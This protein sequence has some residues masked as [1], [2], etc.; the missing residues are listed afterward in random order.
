LTATLLSNLS[1][2]PLLFFFLGAAAVAARSDLDIPNQIAKFLSIYLLFAIGFKGGVALAESTI[3]VGILLTLGSAMLLSALIP[4]YS[5]FMLRQA[6]ST[7]SQI[8]TMMC[9]HRSG[10]VLPNRCV[11]SG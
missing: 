8:A 1:S 4:L 6:V 7:A 10:H 11:G 9:V 3:H 5:F 2:P